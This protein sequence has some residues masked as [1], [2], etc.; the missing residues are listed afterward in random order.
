[1]VPK[2]SPKE[3]A[4][5]IRQVALALQLP[6][7]LVAP[8]CVGAAI[9]YF[10][11]RWLRTGPAFMIILVMVGFAIGVRDTIRSLSKEEKENN[12]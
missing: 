11:D 6:L 5:L 3:R 8:V 4:G 1:M 2:F 7:M 9:G 10:V 12:E